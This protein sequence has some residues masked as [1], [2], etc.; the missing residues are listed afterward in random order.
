M[1]YPGLLTELMRVSRGEAGG[2]WSKN[3]IANL[4]K[5]CLLSKEDLGFEDLGDAGFSKSHEK[6]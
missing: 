6:R 4:A 5:V 2:K 3:M 1:C